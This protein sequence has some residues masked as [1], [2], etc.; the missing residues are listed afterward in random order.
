ME[1]LQ[2]LD[3]EEI[4]RESKACR[5]TIE[6]RSSGADTEGQA[7]KRRIR[8]AERPI[9]KLTDGSHPQLEQWT[10]TAEV[11]LTEELQSME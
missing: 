1:E 3:T 5:E 7:K 9:P 4:V 10:R 6:M 8:A 2:S 11:N